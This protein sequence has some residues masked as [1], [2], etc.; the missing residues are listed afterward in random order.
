MNSNNSEIW[1]NIFS[2]NEW[3]KY[4]PISLVKFIAKNFYKV[5]D[6]KLVRILEIGSGPGANLW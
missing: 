5:S 2:S 6:R 4:P 3:G 1:E